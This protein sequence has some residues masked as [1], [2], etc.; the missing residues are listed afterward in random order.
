MGRRPRTLT[1]LSL[2]LAVGALFL[3]GAGDA[4]GAVPAPGNRHASGLSPRP[5]IPPSEV[6]LPSA[7]THG[8]SIQ[9]TMPAVGLSV[10]YP[11][12]AQDLGTGA[13]PSAALVGELLRLGSPPLAL[14]GI[15]QDLTAPSGALGSAPSSW[16]TAAL[17]SLPSSFWS[18]LHCMLTATKD[19]LTAGVNAK[20]G[21]PSWAAQI[22]AGAQ[23]AAT[24]G[25]NFSL[26]NE[27]DLYYLPNYSSLDKPQGNEEATAVNLYLQ[28]AANLQQAAGGVPLLGPELARPAHWQHELPRVIEQLHEQTVGVHLYPL[29]ACASPRAVTI[30]GL[31]SPRVADAPARLAWVVADANHAQV[32]AIISEANS[33]SCGGAAGVSDSPAAAVWAV[34]FVL[35]ALKTGFHEVRFHFSGGPYDAFIVHG[36]EIVR[37]PLESALVALAQWLP[38]GSS[39]QTLPGVK[40]LVATRIGAGP[41]ILDNERAQ[42]RPVVLRT[43]QAV[44]IETL[45]ATQAGLQTA[46][47]SPHGGRI[48]LVV[49]GNSV[50]AVSPTPLPASP[51]P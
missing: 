40:G 36:E 1:A 48:K 47:L 26:G 43:A 10:E 51:A 44:R 33:A 37:R 41:I 46:H 42:P 8:P 38:V 2:A 29:S 35:A 49:A 27:P 20:T 5:A 13:C 19:P 30:G 39:L 21:Q 32:P 7:A 15:S 6:T 24:N 31:L 23:S 34:R 12:M 4:V 25:L 9:V 11:L 3:I 22:V 28:V 45:R 18:Q 16:E 50:A 14:A 17:Y